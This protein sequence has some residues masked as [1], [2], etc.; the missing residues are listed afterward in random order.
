MS[1]LVLVFSS[2]TNCVCV[3]PACQTHIVCN[4]LSS[5]ILFDWSV[6]MSFS[7]GPRTSWTKGKDLPSFGVLLVV[8]V[9]VSVFSRG[10]CVCESVFSRGECV[11][12]SVF[13]HGEC[14]CESVFSRG[15]CVCECV[16]LW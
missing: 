12:E 13:S 6:V 5:R 7:G 14:V 10:E 4:D 2:E 8:S 1:K 11:C 16:F 15:E 3:T 9:Y